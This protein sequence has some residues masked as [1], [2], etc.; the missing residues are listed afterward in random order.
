MPRSCPSHPHPPPP[1]IMLRP[2]RA[3]SWLSTAPPG[4]RLSHPVP[5]A[6]CMSYMQFICKL[7]PWSDC[8]SCKHASKQSS[9]RATAQFVTLYCCAVSTDRGII[10]FVHH[11]PSCPSSMSIIFRLL[12]PPS[13]QPSP[14]QTSGIIGCRCDNQSAEDGPR[15]AVRLARSRLDFPF[16]NTR[17]AQTR[18]HLGYFLYY[19]SA[20]ADQGVCMHVPFACLLPLACQEYE[21]DIG[22]LGCSF[23][24]LK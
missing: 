15:P 14:A 8:G 5:V 2:G 13:S 17:P 22:L 19:S 4:P 6:A 3:H 10:H 18:N 23:A 11:F 20:R 9:P 21:S 12:F 16:L 24:F 7:K 1:G